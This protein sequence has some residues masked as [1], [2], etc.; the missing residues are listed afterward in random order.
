M[1]LESAVPSSQ[2]FAALD[3]RSLH[4]RR[5]AVRG[6][7]GGNRGHVGSTLSLIEILRVLYDSVLRHDPANPGW[8]ERDRCILS[9]GHGCLALYAL[10]ADH[11]YFPADWLD[12]FC[13]ADG[14]LGGHPE[15]GKVPGV[16]ASTGALGHGLAIGVGLALAAR[17]ARRKNRVFV[18][19]GDGEIN[20][21]SVWEAAMS[22]AKHRLGNLVALVDYN[23]MQS[24]GP[25]REVVDLEPLA[26]K[27]R[28]FGFAVRE[29]DGHDVAALRSALTGIPFVEDR[30]GMVICHTVKGRGIPFAEGSAKWHHSSR[31]TAEELAAIDRALGG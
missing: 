17:L 10:L 16:E 26:D 19:M 13:R 5:L 23:K 27:W 6:L 8:A 24:Y 3:D 20:E 4:L 18:I 28:A 11:G 29:V 30:P 2:A 12:R 31:F 22:A 1:V 7:I 21:G 25:T 14:R 15:A 9:K